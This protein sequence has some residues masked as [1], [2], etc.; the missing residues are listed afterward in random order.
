[1]RVIALFLAT[2]CLCLFLWDSLEKWLMPETLIGTEQSE[3]FPDVMQGIV[4]IKDLNSYIKKLDERCQ[5]VTLSSHEKVD[6]EIEQM[7]ERIYEEY[8]LTYASCQQFVRADFDMDKAMPE[9][10][11]IKRE[12]SKLG[13]VNVHAI[14]D[15]K[16]LSER[17][18]ALKE[19]SDDLEKAE[20]N[21]MQVIEELSADA[22]K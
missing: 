9:I 21:L 14:E 17:Y 4:P 15:V 20:Q 10:A 11:E 6:I 1:M 13:Y 8:S 16:L 7:Q 12:I 19:Q 2:V 18:D 5:T 3:V 22:S